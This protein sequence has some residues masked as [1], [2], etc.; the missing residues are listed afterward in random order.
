M[1]L[2]ISMPDNRRPPGRRHAPAE[3]GRRF[4]PDPALRQPVFFVNVMLVW[5]WARRPV[6]APEDES[7]TAGKRS[8]N[9]L[10][11]LASPLLGRP[12]RAC[13]AEQHNAAP[14]QARLSCGRG[15]I[16]RHIMKK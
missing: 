2:H 8:A 5:R 3:P 11:Y 14:F 10:G 6:P 7:A 12:S 1:I 4:F 16:A 13:L 9:P 15:H